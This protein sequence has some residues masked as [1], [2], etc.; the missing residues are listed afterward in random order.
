MRILILHGLGERGGHR[1]R[2]HVFAVS[3]NTTLIDIIHTVMKVKLK[4]QLPPKI[5]PFKQYHRQKREW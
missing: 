2:V 5:C 3:T 1:D 4:K